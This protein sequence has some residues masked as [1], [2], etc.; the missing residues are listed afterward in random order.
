MFGVVPERFAQ[1]LYRR[2]DAVFEINEGILGPDLLSNFFAGHQFARTLQQHGEDSKGLTGQL[3][4]HPL[5]TQFS[6]A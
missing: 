5:L 3:D 4:L 2:V 6:C 1:P